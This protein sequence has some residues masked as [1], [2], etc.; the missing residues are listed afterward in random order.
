[1]LPATK[2]SIEAM[3]RV[4]VT[5]EGTDCSICLEDYE[6]G[7][8]AR[9]MVGYSWFVPDLPFSDAGGGR[10]QKLR[11]RLGAS[12]SSLGVTLIISQIQFD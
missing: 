2:A 10:K 8:E 12:T 11:R 4:V 3:L 1:M 7:G 6:V 5:E 9:E